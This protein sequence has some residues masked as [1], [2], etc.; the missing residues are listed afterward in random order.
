MKLAG[1]LFTTGLLIGGVLGTMTVVNRL[2]E[3]MAGDLDTLLTGEE[4]RYPWK[5]GDMFYEVKGARDA[6]PLLLIH[7]FG[8][9]ASSYEWRKNIDILSTQ[10]RVFVLDLLGF[11]L[12]DRPAIDYNAEVFTDLVGDFTREVIGKP[13]VVVAHGISCAFV[14]ADAYRHAKYYD[15]LVLVSPPPTMLQESAPG[16]TSGALGFILRLPIVGQFVYNLLTSRQAISGYYDRQGFHNPGLITDDL[17]EYV[18]TT[19]HQP[20][21]RYALI[22]FLSD[23]LNVDA[24]EATARL[25]MPVIVVVG[26]E[27]EGM[28]SASEV[29]DAFKQVNAQIEVHIL[30]KCSYHLQDEQAVH[31]NSLVRDFAAATVT[32]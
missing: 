20:N 18:Y 32:Q 8:P 23:S 24:H 3:T 28:F 9:G 27:G 31:F 25:Q 26:R 7:G 21:S 4:R 10:F 29:G 1:K 11:G 2:T 12:S 15:R 5:Y 13:T 6:K 22:S 16:P 19:A 14:I 17:V 30:A